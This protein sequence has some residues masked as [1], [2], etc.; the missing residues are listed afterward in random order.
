MTQPDANGNRTETVSSS[1]CSVAPVLPTSADRKG[2][3]ISIR[4]TRSLIR[5][6]I[7]SLVVFITLA[8]GYRVNELQSTSRNHIDYLA[9]LARSSLPYPLWNLNNVAIEEIVAALFQ[10]SEVRHMVV[11]GDDESAYVHSRLPDNEREDAFVRYADSW[12]HLTTAT[13]IE[14]EGVVL[15]GRNRSQVVD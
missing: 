5:A 4:F 8:V 9:G 15:D 10:D 3:S 1:V 12:L 7:L 6:V 2:A 13:D 14:F 11:V